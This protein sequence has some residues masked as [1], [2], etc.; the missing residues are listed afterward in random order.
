MSPRTT[1]RKTRPRRPATPLP[2]RSADEVLDAVRAVPPARGDTMMGVPFEQRDVVRCGFVGFGA[3]GLAHCNQV[4]AVGGARV[5]AVYDPNAAR[6]EAAREKF[7]QT[8]QPLPAFE[9]DWRA[10]CARDD[11][12]LVYISSPWS[13][14]APQALAALE[15]GKHVAL[16]VPAATTLEDCWRLVNASERTRRHCVILEN[17]CYGRSELMALT[18]ARAGL[19]GT[20][21]HA[22]AGYLHDLRTLL[23]ADRSEGLWRR[24]AH[25]ERNGNLYPTHGLGPVAWYLDIHRGDRFE[26]LVS[27]SSRQASLEEYRDAT[28]PPDDPRRAETYRCG[29]MNTSLI[30]TARGCTILLQHDV[31]SPRPYSRLNRISGT[32][33]AFCDTP[34]R[35]FLDGQAAHQWQPA[36]AF[37][38]RYDHPLWK[39]HGDSARAAGGHGGMDYLLNHRLIQAFHEGAPPDLNVYDAAAWSAPGPLSELSVAGDALSLPFPDFTRGHWQAGP[40]RP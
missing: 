31:V 14:H 35:V 17:C 6:L 5:T 23:L 7:E 37:E 28:L 19:F 18:M 24:Q 40:P 27:M 8:G 25:S 29:D 34:P 2:G 33:G 1:S 4:L 3:R 20:L 36:S 13:W 21:T 15:Q 30:R 10:L 16:E 32:K 12:D 22:E 9:S 39:A 38:G 11:V 26:R